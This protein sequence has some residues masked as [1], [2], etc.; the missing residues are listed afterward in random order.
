M[1]APSPP[2]GE[3]L[4]KPSGAGEPVRIVLS[5]GQVEEV[6]RGVAGVHGGG[7]HGFL[8][9]RAGH[10]EQLSTE[11]EEQLSD[12]KLSQ[13]LLRAFLILR[14]L[15][16]NDTEQSLYTIAR[17]V[18]GTPSTTR[19]YLGTLRQ[20][21]LVEQSETNRKY[22]VASA[23]LPADDSESAT[24]DRRVRVA[25]SRAQVEQ[26]RRSV[27]DAQ[28]SELRGF[29]LARTGL[30]TRLKSPA[31]EDELPDDPGVSRSLLRAL[32][33]L[34]FLFMEVGDQR[35]SAISTGVGLSHSTIH[36]Y[37]TTLKQVELV[38]QSQSRKYRLA[39]GEQS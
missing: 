30:L 39:R 37:L 36:R 33:I 21:G 24:A 11:E 32:M 19:R 15:S 2:K 28:R 4:G 35:I 8:L 3:E 31:R 1:N 7:L 12:P 20:V 29:L 16:L 10:L 38:E 14:F 25:L 18:Q 9:A 5:N 23:P 17:E 27:T 22:R 6:L 13:S 34:R 26:V